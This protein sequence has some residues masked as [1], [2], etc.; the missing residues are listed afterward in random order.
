MS[1]SDTTPDVDLPTNSYDS[2][3]ETL[4]RTI[5]ELTDR[6]ENGRIRDCDTES[7]RIKQYR[8]LA[9]LIRTKQDVLEDKTL[10][11][12]AAEVEA[13]KEQNG[14]PEDDRAQ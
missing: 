12:L 5:A 7:V 11:E 9:Y 1:Q 10:D 2:M 4:N 8:A 6:I 13:L 3:L 14:L